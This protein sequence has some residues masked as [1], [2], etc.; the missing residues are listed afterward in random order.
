MKKIIP[1]ISADKAISSLDN[2]GRFYNILTKSGDN[3]ISI[4]EIGR[5]A[6]LFGNEQRKILFFE[7]SIAQLD[8]QSKERVISKLDKEL[9]IIYQKYKPQ[10]LLPSEAFS[11]GIISSN[12]V[13]T[14][15]PQLADS[16]SDFKGFIVIPIITGSITTFTMIPIIDKYDI[17]ELRDE[18]H[19]KPFL[20]AHAK[21]VGKLPNKKIRVA[22]VLKELKSN[23]EEQNAS[24]KFLEA[25][26]YLEIE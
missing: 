7:L 10:E 14:G 20:I 21:G 8:Q 23:K 2:G 9:Q 6:G 15:V 12:A 11:K 18:E 26:Y 17:Y 4:S 3:V 16:I 1:Y 25:L 13:I 19:A 5:V 22:G 24:E